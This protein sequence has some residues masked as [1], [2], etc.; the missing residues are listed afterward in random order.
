MA[1]FFTSI[2]KFVMMILRMVNFSVFIK[3]IWFGNSAN[4]GILIRNF[5]FV[6]FRVNFFMIFLK[7]HRKIFANK[8]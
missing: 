2:A 6:I 3:N 7:S 5:F 4:D 8:N 1:Y